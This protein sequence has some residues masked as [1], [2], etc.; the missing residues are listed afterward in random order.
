MYIDSLSLAS[1]YYGRNCSPM[2]IMI[3]RIMIWNMD[4]P[5]MCLNITLFTMLSSRPWGFLKSS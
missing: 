4:W 2:K 5:M 1:A 3:K